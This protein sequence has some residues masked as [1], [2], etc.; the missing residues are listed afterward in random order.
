MPPHPATSRDIAGP[1]DATGQRVVGVGIDL[2]EVD[3]LHAALGR[4]PG[5]AARLFTP[6]EQE[7][8]RG[9][10]ALEVAQGF[11]VKEAVMKALGR[12][13]GAI[14]FTE[15]ELDE[16]GRLRLAGRATVR[17]AEV[18]ALSWEV[19]VGVLDGPRGPVALAEVVALTA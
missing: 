8:L 3:R 9:V 7:R 4:Q 1:A 5:L 15:V 16:R 18:G 6:D 14:A 19:A 17:A 13:I 12:G 11:A 2:V 10:G